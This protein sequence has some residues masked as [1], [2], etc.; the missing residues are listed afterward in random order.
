M[1][2]KTETLNLLVS[3][4]PKALVR[5]HCDRLG[6]GIGPELTKQPSRR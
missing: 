5:E 2:R 4:K 1:E 3:P 6:V